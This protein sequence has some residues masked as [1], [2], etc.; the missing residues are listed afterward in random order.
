MVRF[1]ALL[2]VALVIAFAL[3]DWSLEPPPPAARGN[4]D[5][6]SDATRVHTSTPDAVAIARTSATAATGPSAPAG[7]RTIEVLVVDA[8]DAPIAHAE[9]AWFENPSEDLWELFHGDRDLGRYYA[10]ERVA[11]ECGFTAR[12]DEH[13]RARAHLVEHVC[14]VGSTTTHYGVRRISRTAIPE[15]DGLFVLRLEP[16]V[17]LEVL[18]VDSSGR[19]VADVPI[20]IA[21]RYEID[22]ELWSEGP[23]AHSDEFG[24]AVVPH[25]RYAIRDLTSDLD[26]QDVECR[27]RLSLTGSEDP[28]V[29]L[30][31]HPTAPIVLHMPATGSVRVRLAPALGPRPP[32]DDV[33]IDSERDDA[34]ANPQVRLDG[35][36]ALRIDRLPLDEG[37]SFGCAQLPFEVPFAGP[38][39]PEQVVEVVIAPD[40]WAVYARLRLVDA[41]RR[42]LVPRHV[43]VD[44]DASGVVAAKWTATDGTLLVLLGRIDGPGMLPPNTMHL[45]LDSRD[46]SSAVVEVAVP[47]LAAGV[48]DLGEVAMPARTRF[49]GGTLVCDGAPFVATTWGQL[50]CRDATT[51][52]FREV[53]GSCVEVENGRFTAFAKVPP[54][55]PCRFWFESHEA[56]A[57][58]PVHAVAGSFEHV[59]DVRAGHGLTANVLAPPGLDWDDLTCR[60]VAGTE[61]EIYREHAHRLESMLE[62]VQGP[63]YRLSWSGLTPGTY[64]LELRIWGQVEPLHVVDDIRLP[65]TADGDERLRRIDLRERVRLV[66]V[67]LRQPNGDLVTA[68]QIVSPRPCTTSPPEVFDCEGRSHIVLPAG[69]CMVDVIARGFRPEVVRSD[70]P[71]LAVTLI[72]WPTVRLRLSAEPHLPPDTELL[73]ALTAVANWE[74]IRCRQGWLDRTKLVAPDDS[75]ATFTG[76]TCDVP[77]AEGPHRL[78]LWLMDDADSIDLAD[79]EPTI[80]HPGTDVVRVTVTET[81]WQK[82]LRELRAK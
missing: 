32:L 78:R 20:E 3:A 59:V 35:D 73:A 56:I 15:A 77:I 21:C 69:P 74:M 23:I 82:A 61:H 37:F 81:S 42:A 76:A 64:R 17:P 26:S 18:V 22:D 24:R 33:W 31:A 53:D 67:D 71:R 41:E 4:R 36:D 30:N 72:P 11:A 5:A 50:Q 13:G 40:P 54:T 70:G 2:L 7:A 45:C 16:D 49:G 46:P 25:L 29:P 43:T 14:L 75:Y 52:E 28:G 79:I 12:T 27:V 8:R 60:L 48:H 58:A 62:P 55:T 68:D 80:V 1:V 57:I 51:G 9:L 10:P 47:A 66:G 38:T 19:P 63:L 34:G 39:L 65:Q 6:R 44:S